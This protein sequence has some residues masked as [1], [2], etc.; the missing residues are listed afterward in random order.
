MLNYKYIAVEGNIGVG[1]TTFVRSLQKIFSGSIFLEEFQ[2]NKFLKEFYNSGEYSFETEMQFLLDRS[3]QVNKFFKDEHSLIFSDF[4]I[5]KSLIFSKMN[6]N[7]EDFNFIKKTHFKLFNHLPRPDVI[8]FLDGDIETITTNIKNR[9]REYE[10]NFSVDYLKKLSENYKRWL[11]QQKT[12]IFKIN[13]S[14]LMFK[15]EEELKNIFL[16]I[17]K[18]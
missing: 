7:D 10:S 5:N 4:H 14:K 1:K 9:N 11:S 15:N 16:N 13:S 17:F 6:L 12:P 3:L 8:I 2:E 18:T